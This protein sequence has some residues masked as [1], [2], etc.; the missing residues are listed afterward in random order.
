MSMLVAAGARGPGVLR[1]VVKVSLGCV[2]LGGCSAGS[3]RFGSLEFGSGYQAAP[4]PSQVSRAAL[5][6]P[7]PYAAPQAPQYANS[8]YAA[9]Q[10]PVSYQQTASYQPAPGGGYQLASAA[11]SQGAGYL[12][13]S[14]VDLP[15]LQQPQQAPAPASGVRTADGYGRYGP[16]P[17]ADGVYTG[18]RIYTPYDPP[19]DY[20][21]PPPPPDG[22]RDRRLD[23]DLPPP[24]PPSDFY[25]RSDNDR[26]PPDYRERPRYREGERRDY[27]RYGFYGRQRSSASLGGTEIKR[28]ND[29]VAS[30][31]GEG[32]TVTVQP[33]DTLYSLA[34]R[35]G[36]TIDMI[37][38]ANGLT[39][40]YRVRPGTEL[41]IPQAGPTKFGQAQGETPKAQAA[42]CTGEQCYKVKKGETVASIARAHGVPEAQILEANNLPD[43]RSL[44]AG[45]SIA[46]PGRGEA[47]RQALAET[48]PP[49]RAPAPAPE[50]QAPA[51]AP[52]PSGGTLKAPEPLKSTPEAK[53]VSVK[54]TEPSCD[55][56]LAN[57]L[58]RMG[59]NFRK[60]VEGFIIGQFGPQRDGSVNEGV[61]IS[62]PKGTQIKAAENGVVAYVGDELPGFGNLIL[63]RHADEYV[64]AYAHA[65]EILVRKCDVVKRGQVVAKAG[66]TGD[67]SQPQLHFEIRKNAKPVDPAPLL[68]S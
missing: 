65:D 46:I 35:H 52:M 28:P 38:R 4:S 56:A 63:I 31:R 7:Q 36:V 23:R 30:D 15:P 59:K 18:P 49:A 26:P 48:A 37:A 9:S 43:A 8:Q 20:A 12:Q 45:Q 57:P 61:T 54:P 67:A 64:T 60:P 19:R 24:P 33:G 27:E 21:P 66:A 58:P 13:V 10:R 42:E 3:E 5:N 68:G 1:A 50:T 25:R 62:V 29:T 16:P 2:L 47:P 44:K 39:N 40:S 55:A 6:A 51:L 14:R 53:P 17:L 22:D 32:K 41:L 11:P 34:V